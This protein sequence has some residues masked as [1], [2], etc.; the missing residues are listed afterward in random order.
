MALVLM[1]DLLYTLCF[2]V[3]GCLPVDRPLRL[4][5]GKFILSLSHHEPSGCTFISFIQVLAFSHKAKAIICSEM[6]IADGAAT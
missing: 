2:E 5:V 6:H 4:N 3:L 1:L